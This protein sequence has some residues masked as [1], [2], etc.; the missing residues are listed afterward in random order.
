MI[1]TPIDG[2]SALATSDDVKVMQD[3]ANGLMSY[4]RSLVV[5]NPEDY[6][7][8]GRFFSEVKS[9]IKDAESER[10]RRVKPL[11][12]I[13]K[14][15]NSDYKGI[16]DQLENIARTVETVMVAYKREEER[17]LAE[18]ERAARVEKER[19]EREAR[20]KAEAEKKRLEEIRQEQE[21]LAKASQETTPN[22]FA[23]I[24]AQQAQDRL[25]EEEAEAK[26]ATE[27]ALRA[28]ATVNVPVAY[29][30]KTT[31]AGTSFR[32]NWKFRIVDVNLIRRELM[33]PDEQAIGRIAREKKEEAN[34]PGVEFYCE[35][36][37]G[38]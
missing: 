38:G 18:A 4:A 9:K 37:I 35:E 10:V 27:D 13:V 5:K 32:K 1:T 26:R 20:E 6:I 34:E 19:L 28:A 31:A 11:N 16:T 14:L 36:R 2:T 3:E 15:I 23:A 25:A 7:K 21:R 12:D 24:L 22:P 29:V 30:P 8:A 17:Q 33:I